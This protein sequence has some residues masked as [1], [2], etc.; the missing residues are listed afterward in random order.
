MEVKIIIS[1][2]S[3]PYKAEYINPVFLN[4]VFFVL[5]TS[6]CSEVEYKFFDATWGL[7][8]WHNAP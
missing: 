6:M 5:L 4:P 7:A 3:V 2:T 8:N 1:G